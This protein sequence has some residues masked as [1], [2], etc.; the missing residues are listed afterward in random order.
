MSANAGMMEHRQP[1]QKGKQPEE[2]KGGID[3]R[4]LIARFRSKQDIYEYLS[5]HRK[6]TPILDHGCLGQYYLPPIKKITKDFLKEVFAG[7]KHLI[8]RLQLRP[9]DIPRYDE[10]SVVHLIKDIMAQPELAKMFPEQK[11]PADLP[12]REYFFNI[13]NTTDHEYLDALIKHAQQLRFA[14]K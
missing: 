4:D 1:G 5:Q 7:R 9:I 3:A 13:I 6:R 10:L 2:V 8:P 14:G 12:D 11:T